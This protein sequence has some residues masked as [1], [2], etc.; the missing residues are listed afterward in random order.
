MF[1]NMFN[2]TISEI[3]AWA[4]SDAE[5]PD[6]AWDLYL[7]WKGEIALFLELAT[8]HHCNKQGYFKYLLYFVVVYDFKAAKTTEDKKLAL[9]AYLDKSQ[10]VRHGDVRVWRKDVEALQKDLASFSYEIWIKNGLQRGLAWAEAGNDTD[11]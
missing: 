3:R 10:Q 9:Q 7:A 8:D 11:V 2:P 4:Y 1:A 6:Q 5:E